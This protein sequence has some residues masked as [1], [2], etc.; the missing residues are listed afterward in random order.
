MVSED[1]GR[2]LME[3]ITLL[4]T[5]LTATPRNKKRAFD[6]LGWTILQETHNNF[7]VLALRG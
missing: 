6:M 1:E 2:F 7:N 4:L 3:F 5:Q